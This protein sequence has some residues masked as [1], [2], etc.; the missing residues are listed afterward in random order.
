[1]LEQSEVKTSKLK[2][3][4]VNMKEALNKASLQHE[5]LSHEKAELGTARHASSDVDVLSN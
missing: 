2:E 1:M 3:E 5:V 4:A